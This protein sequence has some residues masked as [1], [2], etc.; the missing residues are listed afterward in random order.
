MYDRES[1]YNY[2]SEENGVSV[3]FASSEVVDKGCVAKN[4]L[5]SDRRVNKYLTTS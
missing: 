3:L 2:T 4:I 1:E 5:S